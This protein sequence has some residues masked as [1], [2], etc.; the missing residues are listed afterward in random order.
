MPG[1]EFGHR[2][3]LR[4]SAEVRVTEVK[5]QDFAISGLPARPSAKVRVVN[6]KKLRTLYDF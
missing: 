2:P 4:P 6:V 1:R 3:G 5:M